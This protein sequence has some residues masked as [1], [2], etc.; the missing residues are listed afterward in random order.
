MAILVETV[1]QEN[2]GVAMGTMYSFTGAAG[3]FAPV[4]GG[5]LYDKTGFNGVFGVGMA[6]VGVDFVLRALMIEKKVR[7]D[8]MSSSS[9]TTTSTVQHAEHAEQTPLLRSSSPTEQP[10]TPDQRYR[11]SPPN[12]RITH[13]FPILLLFR[14]P[15][16]LTALFI[17]FM[18][19]VLLGSF[20]A[21]VPLVAE[22]TFD[23]TSLTAGLLFLPL[24]GADML[25]GPVFGW[26]VDRYG[27]RLFSVLGFALLV[28]SLVLLRLP[29]A[30]EG[31]LDE[32]RRI[33]LFVGLLALNGVG[34]AVV[35]SPGVVEAGRLVENYT[36]ANEEIFPDGPPWAQLY[37]VNSMV[38]SAGLSVGPLV[39][40]AL[41]ECIGYGGMNA[42][43]G[44][45]CAVTAGLAAVFVGRKGGA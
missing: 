38:F 10:P 41:T 18:Q 8:Y 24:G 32:G 19:A 1:G 7:D 9:G 22:S 11:L 25:F 27:P 4:A 13:G 39:A 21:T 43:L 36:R 42:V 5:W 45:A 29:L 17:A 40:G 37:G 30:L 14:D 44:G 12:H 16:L 23:F 20:D 6:L 33:A 34:L 3:L 35:G 31:V 2:L 15:G 26:A 28:P